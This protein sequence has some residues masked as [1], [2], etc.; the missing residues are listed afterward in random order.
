LINNIST[1]VISARTIPTT[2]KRTNA[3]GIETPIAATAGVIFPENV[4]SLKRADRYCNIVC[5]SDETNAKKA[6]RDP[7]LQANSPVP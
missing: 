4:M 3:T 2:D 6:E 7:H 5:E 1:P